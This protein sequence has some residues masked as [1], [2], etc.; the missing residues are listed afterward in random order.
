MYTLSVEEATY[1]V[2]QKYDEQETNDS[3]MMDAEDEDNEQFLTLIATLLPE[4]I[5]E[6]HSTLPIS[7]LDGKRLTA[8]EI[9]KVTVTQI[10]P[11]VITIP[12]KEEFL[13]LVRF[14]ITETVGTT[15]TYGPVI[16]EVV[17]EYSAEGRMQNN[18]Y[19]RATHDRPRL[20]LRQGKSIVENNEEVSKT[21]LTYHSA[22]TPNPVIEHMEYIPRYRYDY[23][24]P[25]DSYD[26]AENAVDT[27]INT[28]VG[29]VLEVYGSERAKNYMPDQANP[30]E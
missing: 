2:K 30:E 10:E 23:E 15:T 1:F 8:E 7:V 11:Y 26:V 13:R 18:P 17:P 16:T 22:F 12:L 29:R 24:D 3:E 21:I 14:N 6:V 9:A 28:L 19:T 25:E 27:I 20:V 4:C 5:N